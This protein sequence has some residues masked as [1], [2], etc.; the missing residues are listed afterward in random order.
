MFKG[1][2]RRVSTNDIASLDFADL[3]LALSISLKE[4]F[5]DNLQIYYC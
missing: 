3:I 1:I 4:L 5:L 2:S